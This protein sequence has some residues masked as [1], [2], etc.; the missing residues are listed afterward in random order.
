MFR[1]FYLVK[2]QKFAN[3]S[4]ATKAREKICTDLESIEF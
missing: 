2:N 1:N 4:T 3:I